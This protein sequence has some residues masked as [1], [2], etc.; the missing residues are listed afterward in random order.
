M[1]EYNRFIFSETLA[2]PNTFRLGLFQAFP[3][4]WFA[5]NKFLTALIL[6]ISGV[7]FSFATIFQYLNFVRFR[8]YSK[9]KFSYRYSLQWWKPFVDILFHLWELSKQT[10]GNIK[11]S[12]SNFEQRERKYANTWG[13]GGRAR[14]Q[15]S[16]QNHSYCIPIVFNTICFH[17][18]FTFMR[19]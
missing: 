17:S 12:R 15:Q 4:A 9:L 16:L 14:G 8:S 1:T 3:V 10:L 5:Q 18:A 11:K 13:G 2:H 6:P 7:H 19:F